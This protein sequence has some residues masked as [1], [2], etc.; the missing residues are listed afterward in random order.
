MKKL[1]AILLSLSMLICFSSCE[2]THATEEKSQIT[3]TS[4]QAA[5]SSVQSDSSAEDISSSSLPNYT[6][7]ELVT[8]VQ[9]ETNSVNENII[10]DIPD[11]E[12]VNRTYF[13]IDSQEY[14]GVEYLYD[15]FENNLRTGFKYLNME[16]ASD[17]WSC[18]KITTDADFI[19]KI[20]ILLT[21]LELKE[22]S[23]DEFLLLNANFAPNDPSL[24][25]PINTDTS[26]RDAL[27]FTLHSDVD[28]ILITFHQNNNSTDPLESTFSLSFCGKHFVIT[29]Y[30][31]IKDE[32]LEV[33]AICKCVCD[34]E[35]K[36]ELSSGNN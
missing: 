9:P 34:D 17:W 18:E 35:M 5:I 4:S 12:N 28:L 16:V 7:E 11:D 13:N 19:K 1:L 32:F 20:N 31:E 29:N 2:E 15:F 27:Y 21:S 6:W 33:Y 25:A 24:D 22:I 14:T 36:L 8:K 30:E 3:E 10:E 26:N 23:D